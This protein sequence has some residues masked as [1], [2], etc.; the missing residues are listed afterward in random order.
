MILKDKFIIKK[1]CCGKDLIAD[2]F[3]NIGSHNNWDESTN[4]AAAIARHL[5]EHKNILKGRVKR[6]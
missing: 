5:L 3:I 1:F 4:V 6:I 2:W